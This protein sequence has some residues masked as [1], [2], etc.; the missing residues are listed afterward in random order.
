ML[1]FGTF[2][3]L[4]PG[5]VFFINKAKTY[6]DIIIA[7]VA[8]D[9]FVKLV[10]KKKPVN[11]QDE[12]LKLLIEKNLVDKAFLSDKVHG[13]YTIINEHKPDVICIGY[14]QAELYNDLIKWLEKS[15]L[16]IEVIQI[17]SFNPEKYKS[18]KID[19][20]RIYNIELT[21][22]EDTVFI[23]LDLETTG[24]DPIKDRIVEIG[25]VLFNKKG[26][27]DTFQSFVNP[28]MLIPEQAF[29]IHGINNDMVKDSA[30]IEDVLR[31]LQA[32]AHGACPV[33]HNAYFDAGF[34][35]YDLSRNNI[36]FKNRLVFDTLT[37]SKK[38]FKDFKSHSLKNL[39]KELNITGCKFH[40]ALSDSYYCMELF[41]KCLEKIKDKNYIL[42]KLIKLNSNNDGN[43]LILCWKDILLQ[44]G[45]EKIFNAIQSKTELIIKYPLIGNNYSKYSITPV[46]VSVI[47]KK[48]VLAAYYNNNMEVFKLDKIRF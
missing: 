8:R 9:D 21:N 10:K 48:Y 16:N 2:D 13:T 27:I 36:N 17:D 42:E 20:H 3:I 1:I 18:S 22:I 47:K 26:I 31:Q 38:I 46:S 14:D 6:G 15:N 32:F 34:L 28:Q 5:H 4:H 30:L 23:A 43:N 35:L 24:L 19:N 29:N 25:A 33:A 7:S 40:R 39:V 11:S 44:R 45:M 37:I 41:I 12:R